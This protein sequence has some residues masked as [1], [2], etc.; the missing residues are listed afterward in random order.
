MPA[1][2]FGSRVSDTTGNFALPAVC[3][4][5]KR[6][7]IFAIAIF[8]VNASTVGAKEIHDLRSSAK[9]HGIPAIADANGNRTSIVARTPPKSP[10]IQ[11]IQS[12][13]DAFE[14]GEE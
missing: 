13:K 8:V 14:F 7:A 11:K 12:V 3:C 9:F 10:A 2:G 5:L 4:L 1:L 6:T